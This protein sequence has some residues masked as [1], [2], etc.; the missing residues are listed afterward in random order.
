MTRAFERSI[1]AAIQELD[2]YKFTSPA[3]QP[4]EAERKRTVDILG[5][6]RGYWSEEGTTVEQGE[7]L[8]SI[9]IILS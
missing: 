9:G 7:L 4:V 3:N 1:V 6:I 8:R 5:A 2:D